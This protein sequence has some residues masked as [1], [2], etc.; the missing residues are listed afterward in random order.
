[1]KY[2]IENVTAA[3]QKANE[4]AQ[5]AGVDFATKY[6]DDFGTCGFAVVCGLSGRKR[7]LVK[8]LEEI[9]A[10]G[11][12]WGGRQG[13]TLNVKA[14]VHAERYSQQNMGYYEVYHRA[15][16]EVLNEELGLELHLHT[17]VD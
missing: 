14:P 10:L 11:S 3:V 13:Y 1:M 15:F 6:P 9:G 8:I 17:W 7:T 16:C 5:Q 4:A 2:T 12:K